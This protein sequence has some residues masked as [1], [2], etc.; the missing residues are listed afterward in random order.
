MLYIIDEPINNIE[1][2]IKVIHPSVQCIE[3]REVYVVICKVYIPYYV[4]YIGIIHITYIYI[5]IYIYIY[6]Y[7][8]YYI[9]MWEKE[10]DRYRKNLEKKERYGYIGIG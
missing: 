1:K 6:L 3:Y 4:L 9:C 10:R 8:I 2:S 7:I 5:Y